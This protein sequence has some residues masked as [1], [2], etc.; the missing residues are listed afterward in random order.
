LTQAEGPL[1][2]ST[3][4][5]LVAMALAV[6]VVAND[7]T[8]LSIALSAMEQDFGADVT[9]VQWVNNGYALVFG[10]VIVAGGRLADMFGRW[11]IFFLGASLFA[12]F[13]PNV[14]VL[15]ACRAP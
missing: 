13:A 6:L 10:V 9:T 5:G 8:A 1:S 12:V 2:Q 15:L 7:F 11:R 14:G 3:I 4:L